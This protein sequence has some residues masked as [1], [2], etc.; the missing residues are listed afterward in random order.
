M[1][2]Y[3]LLPPSC[4]PLAKFTD[5]AGTKGFLTLYIPYLQYKG[6]IRLHHLDLVSKMFSKDNDNIG[7]IT[8]IQS[9]SI[10]V[11]FS[12]RAEIL[13]CEPGAI[14]VLS[15]CHKIY[16]GVDPA[17][18]RRWPSVVDDGP[19]FILHWVNVSCLLGSSF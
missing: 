15:N 1:T 17:N 11:Q 4:T 10:Y 12:G 14:F 3:P 2:P 5:F 19:T 9:F 13:Q 6:S 7:P 16:T 8:P 18:T